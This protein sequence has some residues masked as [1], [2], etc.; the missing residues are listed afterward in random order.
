VP[1][2]YFH[3]CDGNGLTVDEEGRELKGSKEARSAAVTDARSIMAEEMREGRLDLASFI[4]V[5]DESH[6]H[7]FTVTFEEAVSVQRPG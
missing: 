2:F 4:E 5:E 1:R 7:L 3:V 6:V